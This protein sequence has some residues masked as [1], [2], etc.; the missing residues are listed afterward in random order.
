MSTL[1]IDHRDIKQVHPE[2]IGGSINWQLN[3][4]CHYLSN[5]MFKN[6]HIFAPEL[7]IV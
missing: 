2:I 3:I 1:G 4:N 6:R 5:R 7:S